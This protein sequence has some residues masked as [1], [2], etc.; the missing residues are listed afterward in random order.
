MGI[1]ETLHVG[2]DRVLGIAPLRRLRM[3]RYERYFSEGKPFLAFR[4][5]YPTLDEA[6]QSVPQT[7]PCGYDTDAGTALHV[8][9]TK[10]VWPSDYPV[11]FWLG[12]LF[13]TG[14]KSVFDVG[15]NV[16]VSYYSFARFMEFPSALRWMVCE[17][18]T[19]A[20]QGREMAAER[21]GRKQLAFTEAIG[22]A[23][24]FDVLLACGVIQYLPMSMSESVSKLSSKPRHLIIN[25]VALHPERSFFTVQNIHGDVFVPYHV[26]RYGDFVGGFER[27]GYELVNHW[28]C[29]EKKCIIPFEPGHSVDRFHGFYFRL[30]EPA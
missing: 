22:D 6:L 16:G 13:R 28:E 20:R 30:R 29:I 27:L 9:R 14:C 4:G 10:I 18:P 3:R 25:S 23:D 2:I 17:V 26:I 5:V 21:D 19:T 8:D 15:G 7:L 24:G 11:M 1:A 12:K